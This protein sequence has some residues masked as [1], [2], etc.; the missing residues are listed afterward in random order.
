MARSDVTKEN[1]AGFVEQ[2]TDA[3]GTKL[4]EYKKVFGPIF[5]EYMRENKWMSLMDWTYGDEE[6][7]V[8]LINYKALRET[9][10]DF[11]PGT[12]GAGATVIP[13]QV[14]IKMEETKEV[15]AKW[16]DRDFQKSN[17]LETVGNRMVSALFRTPDSKIDEVIANKFVEAAAE[18]TV[19]PSVELDIDAMAEA[20]T[21]ENGKLVFEA[22][23]TQLLA[24]RKSAA[25]A[26]D[27]SEATKYSNENIKIAI[28]VEVEELLTAYKSAFIDQSGLL[29]TGVFGA[30]FRNIR[31]ATMEEMPAGTHV[32]FFTERAVQGT[33]QPAI[34]TKYIPEA[35]NQTSYMNEV[36]LV[37]GY[38][39]KRVFENEV[40]SI[41]APA[42][43]PAGFVGKAVKKVKDTIA[44]A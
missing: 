37:Y 13:E 31:M 18:N 9:E 21:A 41:I 23:M 35:V 44:E 12:K 26:N 36:N 11:Q 29:N 8:D 38:G 16:Y 32:L 22:V 27:Y 25:D 14:R 10:V 24:F 42:E 34:H 17:G 7:V 40:T 33:F 1:I 20:V 39:M 4:I 5:E 15:A 2:V 28:S 43:E 30:Q 6:R 3:D 19:V